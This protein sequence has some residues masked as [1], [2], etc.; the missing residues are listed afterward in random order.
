MQDQVFFSSEM[1]CGFLPKT[2]EDGKRLEW[3]GSVHLNFSEAGVPVGFLLLLS[4][5]IVLTFADKL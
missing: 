3:H 4:R 1:K 5:K 2:A